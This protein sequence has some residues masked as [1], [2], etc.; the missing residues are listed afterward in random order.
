MA[1]L[2]KSQVKL[3]ALKICFCLSV[4]AHGTILAVVSIVASHETGRLESPLVGSSVDLFL[5]PDQTV[6]AFAD[7]PFTTDID[8]S[9]EVE[10]IAA[11]PVLPERIEMP[12]IEE[13]EPSHEIPIPQWFVPPASLT[14]ATD[15][16]LTTPVIAPTANK[17]L[18]ADSTFNALA[19]NRYTP[20][21][22]KNPQ[23]VYPRESRRRKEE[24][25]VL[26]NVW[27]S[28]T[29]HVERLEVLQSS[30]FVLL[31]NAAIQAVR[32]WQFAPVQ[33]HIPDADLRVEIPIRFKLS[34]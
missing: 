19:N 17:S 33:F 16:S 23:P 25:L 12:A 29:G 5:E 7:P 20:S 21:F 1:V 30:G 31:D 4:L 3:S 28:Q 9:A 24:G 14:P 13:S 32:Q 26:L 2:G 34:N 22:G 18:P 10:T 11:S 6:S 27:I 15:Q 8:P